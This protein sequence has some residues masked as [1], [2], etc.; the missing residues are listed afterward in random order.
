[1]R[2]LS[3][4]VVGFA[5]A[6]AGTLRAATEEDLPTGRRVYVENTALNNQAWDESLR[7]LYRQQGGTLAKGFAEMLRPPLTVRARVM[8]KDAT[9][10]NIFVAC[11]PKASPFHWEL[12]S[13]AGT[14]ALSF[15]M[16]GGP[17]EVKSQ[18]NVADGQWHDVAA[19]WTPEEIR[20][21]ADGECVAAHPYRWHGRTPPAEAGA[22]QLGIARLVEGTIRCKGE[23]TD[24]RI[25]QEGREFPVEPVDEGALPSFLFP[26]GSPVLYKPGVKPPKD[27]PRASYPPA[28]ERAQRLG[29]ETVR[30]GMMRPG[31]EQFWAETVQELEDQIA[32]RMPLPRGAAEQ[33]YDKAALIH[34][35]DRTALGVVLRRTRPL[36]DQ[37]AADGHPQAAAWLRDWEKLRAAAGP[38]D[39]FA[40]CALRR[41][42][43]L[44]HPALAD[45][46]SIAF[47]GRGTYAGC[48]LTNPRNSDATGGHFATQCFGFNTIPGGGLF[49]LR[50]LASDAPRVE[51]LLDGASVQNGPLKGRAFDRGSFYSPEVSYDGASVYF[52]HCGATNH[53][54][55]WTPETVW[56][57]FRLDLATR[58]VWQLTEGPWN[59]FDPA[60]LPCGRIA[61]ISERRGAFIR[62]FGE[63]SRLRVPNFV[64]HSMRRDGTDAYPLSYY[65]TS[66]WAPSVDNSGMIV[67]TRWDY[68]DRD[69]CLGSQIWTCYP[70][71]RD[72]RAP[73]GNYPYPWH[74]FP[75]NPHGDHR[76]G[77][78][79]DAPSGLP[80]SQM[81]TRA[82]PGATR[83][84]VTT[85]APHHGESFGTLGILDLQEPDDNHFSQLRRVTPYFPLPESE[86]PGRAQYKYGTP[87][88]VTGDLFICNRWEDLILLDRHGNEE[89]ICER[90]LL[91]LDGYDPRL[92]LTHPKP[93]RARPRPPV[94]P[95]H[96]AQGQD[97]AR[98]DKRAT[99]GVADARV[100]DLP[101]PQGRRPTSLRV[102]QI[103]PKHDPWMD[104]PRIGYGEENTPRILLGAAP[105]ASDGSAHFEA[106][107]GKLLIFQVVDENGMAIQ[108]MRTATYVHPGE[109]LTCL[110]CHEPARAATPALAEQPLAFRGPPAKLQ[111]EGPLRGPVS[112]SLNVKPITERRCAAC[113]R[114]EG[115]GPQDMSFEG[116]RP[117][118][119]WFTGGFLGTAMTPLHGGSR[120]IPG[121]C[122]A[123][124]S[125]IGQALLTPAHRERVPEDE[126]RAVFLWLDANAPRYTAFHDLP[127]QDTGEPVWPFL[128]CDPDHLTGNLE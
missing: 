7:F 73:H 45:Y 9:G 71:G 10:F 61:F 117:Y 49:A 17:G 6:S 82:L 119:Y 63:G 110:G 57:L 103:V 80:M 90:E 88:P 1:M 43:M 41:A 23:V 115:K 128:D 62:C 100:S 101:F 123:A 113:H 114:R 94:I 83:R 40:A 95:Q 109:R 51:N 108:T 79:P 96:T 104:V 122:G 29:L 121:R 44:A 92:R 22:P 124:A 58:Q 86:A 127:R 34:P 12:Y 89:L 67:Y 50:G 13:Y 70:D 18:K 85:L 46:A 60:E 72:P 3:C 111:P 35:D 98:A 55:Q 68:T 25:T 120:S 64:L 125:K 37:M 52:A 66:E 8:A 21:E 91:P 5:L 36:I 126:R 69:D 112:Y 30:P 47:I 20:L 16:P 54:W 48:R 97:A 24:A 26:G 32:G 38:G 56:K 28:L 84:Y 4:V 31:V 99:I 15:Y 14:G 77:R 53:V 33:V 75:D 81:H 93:L 2:H 78:C 107:A 116:L 65:E 105:L 19:V 102:L 76:F 118:A 27:V 74:T 11:E 42:V 87:W 106:P 39:V 59:D